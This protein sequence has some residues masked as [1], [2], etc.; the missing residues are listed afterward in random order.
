MFM[1][2]FNF[3]PMFMAPDDMGGGGDFVEEGVEDQ[4][5]ADPEFEEGAEETEAADPSFENRSDSAF[6]EMRRQ[7]EEYARRIRELEAQNADYD[8][9]LGLY[10]EGD[11]KIAQAHAHFEDVPVEQV[12]QNMERARVQNE[13]ASANAALKEENTQLRYNQLK[14]SDLSAI[15]KAHPEAELNDVEELGDEF[16]QYRTMGIDA[17]RVYEALQMKKGT[18]PKPIGKVKTSQP[19]ADTFTREEVERMSS[20]ERTANFEKIKKSMSTWK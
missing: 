7:N 12:V 9:A 11:N 17:V 14:S 4:E 15:K 10:F 6:A 2:S 5:A 8:N 20:K 13:L 1:K 18:P 19:E 16:F 3:F